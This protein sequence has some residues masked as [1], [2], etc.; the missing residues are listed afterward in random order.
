MSEVKLN[1]IDS[2][3]ILTGTVHGSV[4]DRCIAA[5]SAEPETILELEVALKRFEQIDRQFRH[6]KNPRTSTR[7]LTTPEY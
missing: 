1:L 3:N 7:N 4:G 5:L 6:F 2:E